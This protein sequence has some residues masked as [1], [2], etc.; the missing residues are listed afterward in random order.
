MLQ[1]LLNS[2]TIP[3][4]EKVAS[5]A[6]RR[7]EIL[8]GNLANIDTPGYRTRD[9]PVGA[10]QESLERAVALRQRPA[11]LGAAETAGR[12]PLDELF[13]PELFEAVEAASHN[14]T[15]QDGANRSIE[16]EVMEMTKNAM[17]QN[18]AIEL[19]VAQMNM[20]QAVISERP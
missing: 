17:L 9:L 5:F 14:L 4:L 11:S 1:P 20:M 16:H 10:F 18:F 8:A 7:H 19:M 12:A 3:L 6:E 15:F 2:T 13:S